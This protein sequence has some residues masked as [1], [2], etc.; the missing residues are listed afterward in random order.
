ME[1][2]NIL[3]VLGGLVGAFILLHIISYNSHPYKLVIQNGEGFTYTESWL[4]VDEFHMISD[5]E[6]DV[7]IDGKTMRVKST[8]GIIPETN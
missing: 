4:Y 1:R 2:K 8:R 6:A 7:V 5:T 3:Y